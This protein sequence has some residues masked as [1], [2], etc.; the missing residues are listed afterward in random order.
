ASGGAALR[1]VAATV[2]D[3]LLQTAS[4]RLETPVDQLTVQDGT[5]RTK[6]SPS[7][8]VTYGDLVRE[9]A[10]NE[11]LRVSGS[12]FSLNV[13]GSGKPKN[14]ADYTIVG[15]P[16]KRS[17]IA[18]KVFGRFKYVVDIKVPGMLHGRVVRPDTVGAQVVNVDD[19]AARRVSGFVQTVVKG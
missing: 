18:D 3:L 8:T 9:A 11:Q 1:N 7:R 5:V 16:V 2:R 15:T 19:S 4:K 17:D 12:G 13:Q 10:L 14:P 6:S